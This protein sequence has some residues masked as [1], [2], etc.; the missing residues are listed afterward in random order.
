MGNKDDN[1]LTSYSERVFYHSYFLKGKIPTRK[2]KRETSQAIHRR[3]IQKWPKTY[4]KNMLKHINQCFLLYSLLHFLNFLNDYVIFI[5]RKEYRLYG[6]SYRKLKSTQNW[7]A[8]P[9]V[10]ADLPSGVT[11][12]AVA[13]GAV[14][15]ATLILIWHHYRG[16]FTLSDSP[17]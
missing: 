10:G 6:S 11:L 17:T 2:K 8:K 12:D 15:C 5:I 7:A 1:E 16:L 3:K 9:G 13:G 4:I 14:F